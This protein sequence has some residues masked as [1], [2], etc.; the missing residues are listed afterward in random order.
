MPVEKLH[1]LQSN[2]AVPGYDI[3]RFGSELNDRLPK[4]WP[5]P[6]PRPKESIRKYL[7]MAIL[8][9]V[10]YNV[11]L[12]A[13][14]SAFWTR[15]LLLSQPLSWDFLLGANV[16]IF[17]LFIPFFFMGLI[18]YERLYQRRLPFW[19]SSAI[20]I[21]VCTFATLITIGSLFLIGRSQFLSRLYIGFIWLY[22]SFYLIAA[23]YLIKRMLVTVGLWREPVV[24]IGNQE[25]VA[26]LEKS[27]AAEPDLG[28]QIVDVIEYV[29]G[30]KTPKEQFFS[31]NFDD[32]EATII[33]NGVSEVIIA[34]PELKRIELLGLIY[35]IQPFVR[36][37]AIIPDLQ[38]LP[39]SNVETD[40]F[41]DQQTV[42]LRVRNNLL[43]YHNRLLK[44][45]FDLCFG[46]LSFAMALP[47]MILIAVLVK[48]D[49]PGPVLHTGKRLGKN[50]RK[51]QCYKFRTM[52]VNEHEI[53]QKYMATH[54]DA[55][56]EWRRYA[57]LRAFDPRVTRVGKWL[58]QFSLD[59]LPQIVNVLKGEMSL[60]GPRPYMPSEQE[61]MNFCKKIILGTVPGIT[62]LW[63]VRGRNE[64]TFEERLSLESW[65]VRN[66][67][68][69]LDVTLLIRTIG[70]VLKRRGAY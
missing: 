2:N 14:Q 55:T 12:L 3:D 7:A 21:K 46:A 27:F 1:T 57:K 36:N 44:R 65:Y 32:W 63:Q 41:F 20:L 39:L 22:A 42:M 49:S 28:Y 24:V 35:R 69:W 23:R 53:L 56:E 50:G 38:G 62:G 68:I 26:V 6:Q 13:Q 18:C 10:D 15:A 40:F 70:A 66:W 5:I 31:R 25:G 60:V 11:V 59:E 47:V 16:Q 9:A 64:I 29:P 30:R 67:S 52:Y 19:K 43:V 48:L 17:Y 8:L 61:R 54:P 37:V 58:R 4:V 33:Q 34:L 51:F 45:I